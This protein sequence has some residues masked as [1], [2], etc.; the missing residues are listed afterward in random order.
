MSTTEIHS[1][2]PINQNNSTFSLSGLACFTVGLVIVCLSLWC[3]DDI[4]LFFGIDP[5]ADCDECHLGMYLLCNI[6]LLVR[7]CKYSYRSSLLE[8]QL[9]LYINFV[10][11]MGS[12]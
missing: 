11:V 2:I 9:K 3:P 7:Q 4:A 12:L 1:K 8:L 10:T 6:S 5:L